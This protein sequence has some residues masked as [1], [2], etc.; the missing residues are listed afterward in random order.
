M[1]NNTH[2]QTIQYQRII[3][4]ELRA[5][6][7][8]AL[9]VDYKQIRALLL[10]AESLDNITQINALNREIAKVIQKNYTQGWAEITTQLED[11][12]EYAAEYTAIALAAATEV[13][14]STPAKD[15]VLSYVNKSL[16]SLSTGE[17]SNTGTWGQFVKNHVDNNSRVVNN[18]VKAGY[19]RGDTVQ[20][21]AKAIQTAHNGMLRR[22]AET[23][24]R[25]GV[26]HYAN[27]ARLAMYDDNAD[28][29][30]Y[31]IYSATLDNRTT[32]LCAGRD[33]NR[34]KPTESRPSLPAHYNCRSQYVPLTKGQKELEGVR[35]QVGASKEYDGGV[36]KGRKSKGF[37]VKQVKASKN[38]NDF[39]KNQPVAFQ[40]DVLG[41][42]RAKLFREGVDLEKF[43]DLTGKKLTLKEL[44][45]RG[46]Y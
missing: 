12:A 27:Q 13:S 16:M 40:E 46:L 11:V 14:I 2:Q 42:T 19:V 4:T 22:N 29:I 8:P 44:R 18:L 15:K 43:T 35:P 3:N 5:S 17:S 26:Q 39:L 6:I 32:I 7:Y 36:Y 1:E 20:Q 30:S 34:Y 9:E 28:V 21:T 25:T 37:D 31:Y 45:K 23:L 33:G 41:K 10:D 38:Y 24:A